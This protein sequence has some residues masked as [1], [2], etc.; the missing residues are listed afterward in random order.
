MTDQEFEH[1]MNLIRQGKKEGLGAV[2]EAY[3]P[4]IYSQILAIVHNKQNAEDIAADFFVKLW[5]IA[6]QYQG[7]GHKGWL[8]TIARNMAV[9]FTRKA[10]REIVVEQLP[11]SPD[12]LGNNYE[13]WVCQELTL[14]QMLENL[15]TEE[16][17]IVNLKIMGEFTF[18]EISQILKKPQGTVAW[19]YRIALGKLK[20]CR[21]E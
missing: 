13:D 21:Y 6:E 14:K 10:G 11:E 1:N 18:R 15:D 20:R 8:F 5:N 3:L 17:E 9:D 4:A 16:R 7:K 2:Y 12:H 19:K